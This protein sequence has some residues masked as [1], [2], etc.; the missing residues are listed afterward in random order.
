MALPP[1][2]IASDDV[3]DSAYSHSSK[4][5]VVWELRS[6]DVRRKRRTSVRRR[7]REMEI[8]AT[9]AD[10]DAGRLSEFPSYSGSSCDIYQLRWAR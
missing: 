9:A 3:G 1:L 7:P 6:V 8:T 4:V 10:D 2:A 5:V